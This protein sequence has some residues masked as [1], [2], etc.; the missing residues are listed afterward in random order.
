LTDFDHASLAPLTLELARALTAYFVVGAG[1]L[2]RVFLAEYRATLLAGK[3]QHIEQEVAKGAVAELLT[4]VANR[5]RKIFLRSWTEDGKIRAKAGRTFR[6]GRRERAEAVRIFRVW[7]RARH[8][9]D[10]FQL[11]DICGSL[12]GVGILGWRRYLALVRGGNRPHLIDMKQG[13]PSALT[14][15]HPNQ[16][17]DWTCEAER[18]ATVQN[19]I[20]YVPIAHLGWTKYRSLSF[21]FSDFQPTEDR[22]DMDRLPVDERFPFTKKWGRLLAWAHLR[23]SG[24]KGGATADDLIAYA[25]SFDHA[26]QA[27]LL[28]RAHEAGAATLRAYREFVSLRNSTGNASGSG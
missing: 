27:R 23:G 1:S 5:R 4:V 3:P 7:A 14:E 15:L 20:Q 12:A 22:I 2:A 24:W 21:V 8:Q 19:Y 18:I 13:A 9:A 17:V 28:K 11:T 25:Q 10:F 16:P 6:L 26:A